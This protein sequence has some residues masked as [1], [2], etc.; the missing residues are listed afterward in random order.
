[1]KWFHN[2]HNFHQVFRRLLHKP[3]FSFHFHSQQFWCFEVI[4]HKDDYHHGEFARE[5]KE[6]Q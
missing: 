2:F 5:L 1:M 4:V 3:K 6:K